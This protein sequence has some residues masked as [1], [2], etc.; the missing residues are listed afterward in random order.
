M[1][2]GLTF[3]D[4][5]TDEYKELFGTGNKDDSCLEVSTCSK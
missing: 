1:L 5:S 3:G 4:F 2:Q